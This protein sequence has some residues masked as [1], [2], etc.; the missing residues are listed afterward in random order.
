MPRAEMQEKI[1]A[2][3]VRGEFFYALINNVAGGLVA[4][5]AIF[6]RHVLFVA[7]AK[8]ETTVVGQA[9]FFGRRGEVIGLNHSF[10]EQI[11]NEAVNDGLAEKI[12]EVKDKR[13]FSA[14]VGV[15][16]T[17]SGVHGAKCCGNTDFAFQEGV[18]VI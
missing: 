14:V 1:S 12:H 13:I 15:K 17:D 8:D 5:L 18:T 4:V 11:Q 2:V 9:A 3:E 6:F 7:I 16:K 10:V